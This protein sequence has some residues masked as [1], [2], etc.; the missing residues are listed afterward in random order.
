[1]QDYHEFLAEV[2]LTS[3]QLQKRTAELGAQ[4]SRDYQGEEL[5]LVCILRGGCSF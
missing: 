3:E 1:M 5:I 2:L 4:I